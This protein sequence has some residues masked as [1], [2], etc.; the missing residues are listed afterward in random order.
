MGKT[1]IHQK[2]G[3]GS[4]TWRAPSFRYK[5]KSEHRSY[6]DQTVTGTVTDIVHCQGHSAPLLEV[7][8][9]DGKETL[10]VASEGLRVG[11]QVSAG[12]NASIAVGN[13]LAL[14]AIPEGTLIYNIESLPG[15]GG[16]F[17]RC[18]GAFAKIVGKSQ[19][20]V[21]IILPSKKIKIFNSRCRAT[22]GIVAG[23]GR[24][25]KPFVKAGTRFHAMRAKNKLYPKVRGVAMNAV[26][27]PFGGTSSHHKGRPTVAP[28]YAPAGRN[29][30]K[31]SPRRTG[32]RKR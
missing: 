10:T 23:G 1:L 30:G 5:G 3:K 20:Q 4:P 24:K 32:R 16:K 13:T 12:N 7:K 8:Y 6:D 9:Q 22:I 19:G 26:C 11:D 21:T 25:E 18:S 29:V 27:H 28:R 2:R 15:D 31:I 14:E 17:V